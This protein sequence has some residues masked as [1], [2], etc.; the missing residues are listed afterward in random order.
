MPLFL[1]ITYLFILQKS[2][3]PACHY[4]VNKQFKS[5]PVYLNIKFSAS[6]FVSIKDTSINSI[7]RFIL[8][9]TKRN[10]NP[11]YK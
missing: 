5:E 7:D 2:M 4:L 11:K 8:T 1:L 3:P 9:A 6:I 10:S